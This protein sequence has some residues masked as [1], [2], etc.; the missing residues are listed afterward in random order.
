MKNEYFH[1]TNCENTAKIMQEGIKA[2]KSGDIYVFTDMLVAN[3]IAKE[4]VFADSYSVFQ[5]DRKG[6]YGKILDDDAGE[7][8]QGYHRIIK[9]KLIKPVPDL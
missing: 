7:L 9:Q 3:P 8:T 5:I 1:L 6:V 4:Q 2:N